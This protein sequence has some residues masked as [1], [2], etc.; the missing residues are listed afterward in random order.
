MPVAL[1]TGGSSGI[2]NDIAF[3]LLMRGY[4]VAVTGRSQER[5]NAAFGGLN[6]DECSRLLLIQADAHDLR[7][8]AA[9]IDQV[10]D[11]FGRIDVLVNNVGGGAVGQT[12]AT[13]TVE[14]FD[15]MM[16]LN[17]RSC[18]FMMAAARAALVA[19]RGV[20]INFSSVLATRPVAGLGPYS[21]SKA[22]VEMMTRTAA[23]ELAPHGVR[24][25]CIAPATIQTGFH[26]AAGMATDAAAAYY[27]AS[28][29][30]HPIGRIGQ[31]QDLSELVVFLA[32]S[33]KAGFITGSVIQ[34]DGGRLLTSSAVPL[35]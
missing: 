34:V 4:T 22:A 33:E 32:D 5:L 20:I 9:V 7:G 12:L 29:S 10:L 27:E 11:R 16:S 23:L 17:A 35:R 25:I 1:V 28:A 3:Q 30:A 18:W 14:G 19:S 15:E 24:V 26:V 6:V 8:Y 31:P 2:G 13:S 21:A